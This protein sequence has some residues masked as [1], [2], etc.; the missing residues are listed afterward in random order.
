MSGQTQLSEVLGDLDMETLLDWEGITYKVTHGAS[1]EQLNLKECPS[2]G[3]EDWK[4]FM[5]RE[6]GLGNCFHG[7]CEL[8]SFNKF[9]FI[10]AYLG[11]P[12]KRYVV[13]FILQKGADL[14]WR[15]KARSSTV[16]L[17]TADLVLP[18]SIPI[19]DSHG[20]NLEYLEHR[21]V[22]GE[23]A[24]YFSLRYCSGGTYKFSA[25]GRDCYQDYSS[26]VIIPIF[27]HHGDLVTFQG[28]D[29]TGTAEPKYLFPP[30][31]ASTGR[32]L[33]NAHNAWLHEHVA[34]GEGV[35]DCMAMKV[36]F[37][38]DPDLR[39]IV[40]LASFGV[41]LSQYN[42]GADQASQLIAMKAKGL[43]RVTIMWDGERAAIK[44]AWE[45]ART[46]EQLGLRAFIALLPRD[47]DPAELPSEAV[48]AA[49]LG[50]Q[51]MSRP[52]GRKA[53]LRRLLGS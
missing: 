45:A 40:P 19:P 16:Q 41:T 14:G 47:R 34:I 38:D 48:R 53:I 5:N 29:V 30:G 10:E 43:R 11:S 28:R 50:A 42:D 35:F 27:D 44:K 1:G 21:N 25:H 2:C 37:D 17:A 39:H 15:P 32:Y 24:E 51:D 4:V 12:S 22:T 31:L 46:I 36:A 26:R 33:Y 9:S 49:F 13:D 7:S 8:G 3:H 6:S 20:C 23:V 52:D 18:R